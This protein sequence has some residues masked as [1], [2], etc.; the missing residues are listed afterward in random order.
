MFNEEPES[1]QFETI[2]VEHPEKKEQEKT[3]AVSYLILMRHAQR[4]SG[5][6]KTDQEGNVLLQDSKEI[7]PEG[8]RISRE[9]GQK[10][11]ELRTD[12]A[13]FTGSTEIRTQQTG[14]MVKTGLVSGEKTPLKTL[15][16][17]GK[18]FSDY[19]DVLVT[20]AKIDLKIM[21]APKIIK[22]NLPEN[23]WEVDAEERARIREQIQPIGLKTALEDER[24]QKPL[25][26]AMAYRLANSLEVL[27]R[28]VDKGE[29]GIM[30]PI[31]HGI[32]FEALCKEALVRKL[33]DGSQK[34]GFDNVEEIG[35]FQR[36]GEYFMI[37][38]SRVG[39]K[40]KIRNE[41]GKIITKD[42]GDERLEF[43][44]SDPDRL[45]GEKYWLDMAKVQ[46]LAQKMQERIIQY[47]QVEKK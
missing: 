15:Q 40:E 26:E 46:E 41:E 17:R 45:Q 42:P 8:E 28:K 34:I 16:T 27:R 10:L 11:K 12:W 29:T 14:E 7:T 9:V 22:E 3:E 13:K 44:F 38:M 4:Y 33:P 2:P 1:E 32:F 35:G 21:K 20:L 18:S 6:K 24:I 37:K 23:F 47:H 43:S 31:G 5:E 39:K 36:P 30:T 25:A 19:G